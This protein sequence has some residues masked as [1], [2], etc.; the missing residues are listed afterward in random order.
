MNERMCVCVKL[1][2]SYHLSY[3]Y[4]R[5]Y[6]VFLYLLFYIQCNNIS[7][8]INC[9]LP[10]IWYPWNT[11]FLGEMLQ[12]YICALVDLLVIIRIT[13]SHCYVIFP[14]L[15]S[16]PWNRKKNLNIL[17]RK[18][19]HD[20]VSKWFRNSKKYKWS[21]KLW[22]LSIPHDTICKGC[23]KNMNEFWTF[24]DVWCLQIK[25]SPMKFHRVKKY[26]WLDL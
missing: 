22:D 24:C 4:I 5:A 15:R 18:H 26:I 10:R 8:I 17:T 14:N 21:L 2:L 1:T 23:S 25:I 3:P 7:L 12:W 19:D 13:T 11:L 16:F 6:C 9:C 20:H